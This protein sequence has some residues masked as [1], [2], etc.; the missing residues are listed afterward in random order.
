MQ[1]TRLILRPSVAHV[2][3]SDAR[4]DLTTRMSPVGIE[5]TCLAAADF[6]SAA[7]AD[8]ATGPSQYY[9]SRMASR[10]VGKGSPH[11]MS[12]PARSPCEDARAT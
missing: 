11:R 4:A 3:P 8:F 10:T 2:P 9:P 6:K 12:A 7:S 1:P 5:P